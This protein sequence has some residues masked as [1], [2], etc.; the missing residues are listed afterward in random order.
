MKKWTILLLVGVMALT[1]VVVPASAQ[2]I[3]TDYVGSEEC[4]DVITSDAREWFSEDGVYHVRYGW[5]ECT[6]TVPSEP[7]VSGDVFL[8]VNWNFQFTITHP[9][10]PM[11]GKIR[12]ENEGGYWEGIWVGEIT[13]LEGSSH[14]YAV[15]R[16][17][18]DYEGLQARATYFKDSPMSSTYQVSGFIMNPGGE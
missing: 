18:G 7:R 5:L 12:L 17:Y 15:M 14:I 6:D 4:G 11:W 9:F 13:E 2:T 10:G 3:R 8:T 1:V 16:G